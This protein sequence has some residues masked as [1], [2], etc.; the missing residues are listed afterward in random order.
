MDKKDFINNNIILNNIIN[1]NILKENTKSSY[2]NCYYRICK[3]LNVYDIEY[4]INNPDIFC[5]KINEIDVFTEEYSKKIYI[6]LLSLMNYNNYKIN[7]KTIYNQWYKCFNFKKKSLY[8]KSVNQLPNDKQIKSYF[9][10]EDLL[11]IRDNFKNKNSKEYILISLL[12]YIPPRRQ[13]DWYNVTVFNK[14]D[15]KWKPH[16]TTKNYINLGYEKPYILLSEY[17]TAKYYGLWYKKLEGPILDILKN[18]YKKDEE[19][20]FSSNKNKKYARIETFTNW[21]NNTLKSLLNKDNVSMNTLRHSYISYIF[22]HNSNMSLNDRKI[23][24]KDMG[25]SIIESMMYNIHN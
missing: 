18:K 8:I 20:L 23:L 15:S 16:D 9:N 17:K 5:N 10:W 14:K 11:N 24:A 13:L 7:K 25:H 12:T 3:L 21:T 1:N 19:L 2:I 6:C 4:I 22:K